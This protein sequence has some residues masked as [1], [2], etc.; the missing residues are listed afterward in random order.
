MAVHDR[1]ELDREGRVIRRETRA[2]LMSDTKWREVL[3]A[4]EANPELSVQQCIVKFVGR[5]E[6]HSVGWNPGL[7][8]PRPWIDMNPIGPVPLRSIEWMLFPRV[9]EHRHPDRT[10][11][12][13]RQ[14]QDIEGVARIMSGLGKLPIEWT[15]RG[16]LIRGY[17]PA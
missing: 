3:A 6:E 11:P 16:L 2:S 14:P 1:A 12:V 9:A 10:I 8:P 4:L 15:D 7:Y 13:R 5:P 17:L